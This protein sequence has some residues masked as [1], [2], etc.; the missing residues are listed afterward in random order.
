[1]NGMG[2]A[3]RREIISP[4]PATIKPNVL[5]S[6]QRL[7]KIGMARKRAG[8]R[9]TRPLGDPFDRTTDFRV[10][11][12]NTSSVENRP[13]LPLRKAFLVGRD[14]NILFRKPFGHA[15]AQSV[16]QNGLMLN[17][18]WFPDRLYLRLRQRPLQREG[19]LPHR[20]TMPDQQAAQK[21]ASSNL[22]PV[23]F[24]RTVVHRRNFRASPHR[25]S[26]D[27]F[28]PGGDN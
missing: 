11:K 18:A 15:A 7:R 2:L 5:D 20:Y 12:R 13:F 14:R 26:L 3:R 4:F 25:K 10:K 27:V 16:T 28:E 6:A 1:M 22:P 21:K 23:S 24:S 9:S 17:H 8:K 19:P